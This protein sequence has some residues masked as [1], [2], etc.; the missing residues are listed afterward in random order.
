MANQLHRALASKI[1]RYV[2][3]NGLQAGHHL[4]E[5]SLADLLGTSRGPIRAALALLIADGYVQQVP[6]RGFFLGNVVSEPPA[7]EQHA[8]SDDEGIYLTIA[9]DRLVGNI[10]RTVSEPELMRRYDVSRARL[11]RILMRIAT[12]GWIERREGRGWCFMQLIDSGDAYRESCEL[13][14]MLEP[15]GLINDSFKLDEAILDRLHQQQAMV[16]DGAWETLNQIEFF[17]ID[18]QFHE[19]LAEMSGNR[20][21][22]GT[23]ERQNQLRRLIEYR[24]TLNREHERVQSN[25]HFDILDKLKKGLRFEASQMLAHH[26]GNAKIRNARS[27]SFV[28]GAP[29]TKD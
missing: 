24:Q 10:A 21:L 16:R 7:V 12:E 8:S 13:R 2:R 19:G 29:W 18:A 4:T 14:Q 22:L 27:G 20:F 15:A 11:R 5:V 6:N 26:L 28:V 1:L 25:E 17:E 9:Y 23:I 3:T